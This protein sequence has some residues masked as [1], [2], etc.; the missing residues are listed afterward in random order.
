M[1]IFANSMLQ[2]HHST[3]Y[4]VLGK[5][6]S[7]R[8][9]ERY[10]EERLHLTCAIARSI[11]VWALMIFLSSSSFCTGARVIACTDSSYRRTLSRVQKT[12][13]MTMLR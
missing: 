4:E 10:Y 13:T 8:A 3:K 9:N 2:K 1:F 7:K 11:V 5:V 6:I 12:L